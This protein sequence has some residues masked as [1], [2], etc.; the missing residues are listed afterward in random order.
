VLV[1]QRDENAG[2]VLPL[3]GNG[4][5]IVISHV[6]NLSYID[7]YSSSILFAKGFARREDADD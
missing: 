7:T 4:T 3:G 1:A 6:D 2:H 5:G